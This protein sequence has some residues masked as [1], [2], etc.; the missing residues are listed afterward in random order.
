MTQKRPVPLEHQIYVLSQFH[1]IKEADGQF[2]HNE[3]QFF[4][5]NIEKMKEMEKM[6]I[7]ALKKKLKQE[8]KEAET[9]KGSIVKQIR[10]EVRNESN[11]WSIWW[12]KKVEN[13]F[14]VWITMII[15]IRNI[16]MSTKAFKNWSS[17]VKKKKCCLVPFFAS[18]K[19][20]LFNWPR[21]VCNMTCVIKM[22]SVRLRCFSTEPWRSSSLPIE[23]YPNL[24]NWDPCWLEVRVIFVMKGYAMHHGDLLP[25]AKEIVEI[26]YSE[27]LVKVLFATETFAMGVNMPAKTVI[28]FGLQ[29]NDGIEF[30]YLKSSEYTQM[31]GRAVLYFLLFL[32]SMNP[33]V[34]CQVRFFLSIQNMQNQQ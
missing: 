23:I 24:I 15:R 14:K 9:W 13:S 29:K 2:L 7:V 30:R 21:N 1:I 17:T 12:P 18:L 25:L 20:K 10:R 33:L 4:L 11:W 5:N 27:G 6:D 34:Q 32:F 3:Y 8:K 26:L 16:E 22:R 31:S 19:W 28:Y